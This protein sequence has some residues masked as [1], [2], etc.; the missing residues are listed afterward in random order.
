M[1]GTGIEEVHP[2]DLLRALRL[3]GELGDRD[4]AGVGGEDRLGRKNAVEVAKELRLDLEAFGGGLDG[5]RRRCEIFEVRGQGD[6]GTGL[7]GLL[8]GE[9]FLRDFAGEVCSN[10][11]ETAIKAC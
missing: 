7:V 8:L 11:G 9:L 5:E 4:G 2:D 3:R 6:A 1:T 10:R